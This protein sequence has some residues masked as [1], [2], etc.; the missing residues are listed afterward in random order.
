MTDLYL[1]KLWS[2]HFLAF[3]LKLMPKPDVSTDIDKWNQEITNAYT[4]SLSPHYEILNDNIH[5]LLNI[6]RFLL[7]L[8]KKY[9]LRSIEAAHTAS[10]HAFRLILAFRKLITSGMEESSRIILRSY[11]ETVEVIIVL[12][13]N[14]DIAND[15]LKTDAKNDSYFWYHYVSRNKLAKLLEECINLNRFPENTDLSMLNN[16]ENTRNS[17]GQ[18][19]HSNFSI[20]FGNVFVPSMANWGYYEMGESE[21]FSAH[22]PGTILTCNSSTWIVL[23]FIVSLILQD[24]IL[25]GINLRKYKFSIMYYISRVNYLFDACQYEEQFQK[26]FIEKWEQKYNEANP[27]T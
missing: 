14:E 9:N 13:V 8:K 10:E 25:K 15:Y 4:K 5:L 3:N 7:N 11:I 26:V 1:E 16:L 27:T 18:S 12:L 19:V 23:N 20:A 21:R 22:A 2:D 6:K 17:L 24:S